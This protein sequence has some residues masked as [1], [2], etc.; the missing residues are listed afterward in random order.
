M[1]WP[2][3]ELYARLH[4]VAKNDQLSFCGIK[5]IDLHKKWLAGTAKEIGSRT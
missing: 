2:P 1:R 4:S 3:C 5:W